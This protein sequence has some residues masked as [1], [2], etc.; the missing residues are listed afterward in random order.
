MGTLLAR[1]SRCL[2]MEPFNSDIIFNLTSAEGATISWRNVVDFLHNIVGFTPDVVHMKHLRRRD[3]RVAVAF[4][5]TMSYVCLFG[6]P[7]ARAE[8]VPTPIDADGRDHISTPTIRDSDF[9]SSEF[10]RAYMNHVAGML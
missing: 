5:F 10:K 7:S 9:L 2:A 1:R 6:S 4:V 8:N 3:M